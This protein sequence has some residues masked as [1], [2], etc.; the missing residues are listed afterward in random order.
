MKGEGL[1][2][3]EFAVGLY[4]GTTISSIVRFWFSYFLIF[5]S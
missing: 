5:V 2:S 4:F 1:S 3:Y